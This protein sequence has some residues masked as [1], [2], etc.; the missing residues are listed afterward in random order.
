MLFFRVVVRGLW[1]IFCLVIVGVW[2]WKNFV[3]GVGAFWVMEDV[4]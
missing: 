3:S 2:G 1:G 4:D